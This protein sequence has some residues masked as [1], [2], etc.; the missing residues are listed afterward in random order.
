MAF[1]TLRI[2]K[3][4]IQ[5]WSDITNLGYGM[6]MWESGITEGT[7]RQ[8]PNQSLIKQTYDAQSYR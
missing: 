5:G 2:I 1:V 6:V 7:F 8:L 4:P 3:L